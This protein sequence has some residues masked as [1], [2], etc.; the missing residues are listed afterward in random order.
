MEQ[1]VLRMLD[2]MIYEDGRRRRSVEA[3]EQHKAETEAAHRPD[4]A[5]LE[6]HGALAV[7]RRA[8]RAG[9]S[10]RSTKLPLDLVARRE[11][12]RATHATRTRPSIWRSRRTSCSSGRAAARAT[13]RRPQAARDQPRHEERWRLDRAHWDRS[14]SLVGRLARAIAVGKRLAACSA[15]GEEAPRS[16]GSRA[17]A[18]GVPRTCLP[19]TTTS[20]GSVVDLEALE[21]VGP[22]LLRDAVEAEGAVVAPALQH[23]GE[24]A[25][26]A[27]AARPRRTSGRT[28][29]AAASTASRRRGSGC[30]RRTSFGATPVGRDLARD[31]THVLAKSA[32]FG[33]SML[34]WRDAQGRRHRARGGH[35]ARQ[36]RAVDVARRP[37]AGA[38]RDRLHP[39][40]STRA[41]FPVRDRR[42]RSRTSTRRGLVSPKEARR[43]ERNVLLARRR[44]AGRRSP[45]RA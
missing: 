4:A 18:R 45:T 44:R 35:A 33:A 16:R 17:G 21:Q 24:E 43:L 9:S 42:R 12:R 38:E 37:S 23:L 11:G 32:R 41:G 22:L 10:A 36:R 34:S 19:S 2:G 3:L 31:P 14:P 28:R 13:R 30:H 6:A 15:R 20:V 8:R 5:R 1:N 26:D 7:A 40:R 25:L 27:A 39:R 29:A